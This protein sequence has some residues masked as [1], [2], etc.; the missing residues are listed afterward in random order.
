MRSRGE[1]GFTLV[2]TLVAILVFSLISVGFY[3]TMFSGTQASET[4]RRVVRVTEEAR[5][6]L[7]RMVRDVREADAIAFAGN[8]RF[9]V[10]INFNNDFEVGDA[11]GDG[12]PNEPIFTNSTGNLEDITYL[13]E[14]DTQGLYIDADADGILNDDELLA[15]GITQLATG[16]P[17]FSYY[18]NLLEFDWNDDGVT[19]CL[20]LD[21]AQ[22]H[23]VGAGV[24][25]DGN[26]VCDAPEWPKLSRIALAFTVSSGDSSENFFASSQLRNF[27][28][29]TVVV[30]SPSP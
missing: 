5:L 3:T 4:A 18:S 2:E 20:E 16:A 15:R 19:T 10:L 13:F 25:G 6:G 9:R 11:D 14:P 1:D 30:S 22:N 28:Y 27:G 12:I 17:V 21:D 24:A 26:G 7:N 8:N 23:G 29:Q